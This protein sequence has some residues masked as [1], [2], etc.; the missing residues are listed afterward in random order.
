MHQAVPSQHERPS[1]QLNMFQ[2]S[3]VQGLYKDSRQAL[4]HAE[5]KVA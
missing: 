5:S 3:L 4:R 2:A 1:G